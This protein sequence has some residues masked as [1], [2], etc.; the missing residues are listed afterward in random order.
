MSMNRD[1]WIRLYIINPGAAV[2]AAVRALRPRAPEYEDRSLHSI[3]E[4]FI[5]GFILAGAIGEELRVNVVEEERRGCNDERW[6]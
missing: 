3:R 4:R 6:L 1:D 2:T 5:E